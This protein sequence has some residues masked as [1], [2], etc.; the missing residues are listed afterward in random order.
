MNLDVRNIKKWTNSFL[1]GHTRPINTPDNIKIDIPQKKYSQEG[2]TLFVST[3][4]GE[5]SFEIKQY[6]ES[7][8]ELEFEGNPITL[9]YNRETQEFTLLFEQTE[10]LADEF[11]S[12]NKE[13]YPTDYD[14]YHSQLSGWDAEMH[15][16]FAIYSPAVPYET[17]VDNIENQADESIIIVTSDGWRVC[18]RSPDDENYKIQVSLVELLDPI[19]EDVVSYYEEFNYPKKYIN[20][21]EIQYIDTLED[22]L[23]PEEANKLKVLPYSIPFGDEELLFEKLSHANEFIRTDKNDALL[24]ELSFEQFLKQTTKTL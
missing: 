24:D 2:N 23:T 12:T 14:Y 16:P 9:N 13:N 3:V 5:L 8:F 1:Y 19:S 17:V 21:P 18:V 7:Q 11:E 6:D 15:Q 10:V 20:L 4:F 22:V